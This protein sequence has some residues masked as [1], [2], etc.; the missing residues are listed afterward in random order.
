MRFFPGTALLE[1]PSLLFWS[2]APYLYQSGA[3]LPFIDTLPSFWT[4]FCQFISPF[5]KETQEVL[6][7]AK[8][9][10]PKKLQSQ[11]P[12]QNNLSTLNR[13]VTDKQIN[14]RMQ[15]KNYWANS[16]RPIQ[17]LLNG[18]TGWIE[19]KLINLIYYKMLSL[20]MIPCL[21]NFRKINFMV[22]FTIIG[23]VYKLRQTY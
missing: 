9:I 20:Q 13:K 21:H 18:Y 2:K 23:L 12:A 15:V 4:P 7:K 16:V 19:K 10:L 5:W 3:V 1:I 14:L 6:C 22:Y 11:P 8:E 17:Y